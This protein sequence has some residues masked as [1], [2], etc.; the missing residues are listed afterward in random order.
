LVLVFNRVVTSF[1][2]NTHSGK[3]LMNKF[4]LA[5]SLLSASSFSVLGQDSFTSIIGAEFGTS[6]HNDVYKINA[7]YFLS[8]V[9]STTGPL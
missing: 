9:D 5:A 3:F 6:D 4:I 7:S 1:Y 8:P 2:F